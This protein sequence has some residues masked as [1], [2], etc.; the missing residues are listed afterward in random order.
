MMR[1][2][3]IENRETAQCGDWLTATKPNAP[4]M[5]THELCELIAADP[6]WNEILSPSN[7]E[8]IHGEKG[9]TP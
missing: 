4:A 3:K 1:V 2:V 6:A 5:I 7:A 9:A 8:A